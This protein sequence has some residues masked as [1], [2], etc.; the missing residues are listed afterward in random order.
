MPLR[1]PAPR[2]RLLDRSASLL[3]RACSEEAGRGPRPPRRPA[4]GPSR[5]PRRR[6]VPAPRL[7]QPQLAGHE[8]PVADRPRR[9][10]R[11]PSTASR[12]FR[13]RP[14]DRGLARPRLRLYQ[15]LAPDR[16]R[17][18]ACGVVA[19]PGLMPL[20]ASRRS[21]GPRPGPGS[22]PVTLEA[23]CVGPRPGTP[24][25]RQSFV[26]EVEPVLSLSPEAPAGAGGQGRYRVFR[27]FAAAPFPPGRPPRSP[28]ASTYDGD[29]TWDTPPCPASQRLR[30]AACLFRGRPL[31]SQ[32]GGPLPGPRDAHRRG[33]H[34]P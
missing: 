7:R 17:P 16:R 10:W 3:C 23:A 26:V 32:G 6:L 8:S 2:S 27:P 4:A 31:R 29:G 12:A 22:F 11:G 19:G 5:L 9:R 1:G 14:A 34:R 18:S 30:H 24:N 21:P 28:C 33:R 20:R 15:R 25:G 13:S